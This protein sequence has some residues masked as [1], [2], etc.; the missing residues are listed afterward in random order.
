MVDITQLH[1][2]RTFE[3]H[4][5]LGLEWGND[6]LDVYC[7][8]GEYQITTMRMVDTFQ[9]LLNLTASTDWNGGMTPW[10]CIGACL[11]PHM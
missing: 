8:L 11:E 4:G 6:S 7:L 10:M 5:Q 9:Q 1:I 3:P 2:P